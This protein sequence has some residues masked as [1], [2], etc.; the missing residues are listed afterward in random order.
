MPANT[1]RLRTQLETLYTTY[2]RREY[3]H[4]DPLEAVHRFQD[5]S[6]QE[7]VGLLASSLA[8]GDVR[9]I[10]RSVDDV[11]HR[12]P[13]PRH[14]I[15]SLSVADLR[16][17]FVAFRYRYV[18]GAEL[19]DLLLSVRRMLRVHGTLGR[20]FAEGMQRTDSS[21]LSAL[22]RFVARLREGSRLP[23][24]FLL[25]DPR[26][27]SACKRLLLYLRWMVRRDDV[28][29]G[30]WTGVSPCLCSAKLL[31]PIDTHMYRISRFLGW[32][33]RRA[34][35][36]RTALEVTQV[37]RCVSP[38]DPIRYDFALT[39]LGIHGDAQLDTFLRTCLDIAGKSEVRAM[40]K[41]G[42]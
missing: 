34:P 33:D 38:E 21:V 10:V 19:T 28:D 26:R 40:D 35:D 4:P 15:M 16:E 1:R 2:N 39:R 12:V 30:A 20:G 22:V 29:V 37:L 13:R 23:K 14:D 7:I 41:T 9:Q 18:S 25:P 42:R 36:L 11:L 17:K 6:D 31:A 5:P 27:G 8:F 24:N 3:V 32:T